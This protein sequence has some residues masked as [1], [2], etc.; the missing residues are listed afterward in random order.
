MIVLSVIVVGAAVAVG[1]Q[2]FDNQSRNQ[3]RAAI[4][5]DM[6]NMGIN[7]QSYFRTPTMLGGGGGD[8]AVA[9]LPILMGFI[10]NGDQSLT[11]STPNGTYTFSA[12]NVAG[13]Q[14]DM[15]PIP[16]V[17][18]WVARAKVA[19]DGRTDDPFV[20]G[21]SWERGMWTYVGEGPAPAG[22]AW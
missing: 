16:A 22:P 3:A 19:F 15:D 8:F 4:T 1:I 6:L 20:P 11:I 13:V 21:S 7:V 14:M 9:Q 5:T 10:N 2:M 18:G 17:G 12:P